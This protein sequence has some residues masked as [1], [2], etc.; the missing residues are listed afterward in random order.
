MRLLSAPLPLFHASPLAAV[1][2][3]AAAAAAAESG[4]SSSDEEGG[5]GGGAVSSHANFWA[6]ADPF[7]PA[8]GEGGSHAHKKSRLVWTQELHN[9]FI[10]ALSHLGLKSAVPKSILSMMNVEGMTRENVAS[11][12]QKYRLHLRRLGGFTEKDRVDVDALQRLHEQNVQQLAA[13]QV[14]QHTLA[15]QGPPP[16]VLAAMGLGGHGPAAAAAAAPVTGYPVQQPTSTLPAGANSVALPPP[17]T[18]PG[19]ATGIAPQP[20]LPPLPAPLAAVVA[21]AEAA[22][23]AESGCAA[24]AA[25]TSRPTNIPSA[26][27]GGQPSSGLVALP[28]RPG[29]APTGSVPAGLPVPT[30]APQN[31]SA[32]GGLP[33]PGLRGM[34]ASHP[35]QQP[36]PVPGSRAAQKPQGPSPA[37]GNGGAAAQAS[38][39]GA[40]I[41]G[42]TP[43][44]STRPQPAV[45][46]PAV[47]AKPASMGVLP[48]LA[49]IAVQPAAAAEHGAPTGGGA[50]TA[51]PST[52]TDR[53]PPA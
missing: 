52:P 28:L 10:N 42:G 3:A 1:A 44:S 5:G 38:N 23:A 48:L 50:E 39:G 17:G 6:S 53:G 9:R 46:P 40:S 26:P 2:A 22:A 24:A 43:A 15:L 41:A 33:A 32:A 25:L 16:G 11:H 49:A 4:Y 45:V 47:A 7:S 51:A 31:R 20:P 18:V 36:Q 35:L 14:L 8:A 21:A 29:A 12:L 19:T 27:P 34:A 30:G 37:V 13:Q